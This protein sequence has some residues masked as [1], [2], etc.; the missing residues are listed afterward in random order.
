MGR[1]KAKKRV[2]LSSPFPLPPA[3]AVRV[4]QRRLETSQAIKLNREYGR[5]SS[6]VVLIAEHMEPIL[7]VVASSIIYNPCFPGWRAG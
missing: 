6:R 2:F 5:L 1:R 7:S 3:L 4:T